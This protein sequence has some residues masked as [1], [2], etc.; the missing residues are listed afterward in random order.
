MGK[1]EIACRLV[2]IEMREGKFFL[3]FDFFE[4]LP[5]T[6][7]NATAGLSEQTL[8]GKISAK[9]KDVGETP[10]PPAISEP[11]KKKRKYRHR[12]GWKAG[13]RAPV[14]EK[15]HIGRP[16]KNAQAARRK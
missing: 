11:G 6:E 1:I 10:T 3:Q 9:A 8:H 7:A 5:G 12:K 15:K 2:G 14:R 13:Q 16:K 4:Q